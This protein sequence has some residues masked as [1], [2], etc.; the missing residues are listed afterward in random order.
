MNNKEEEE[1][2]TIIIDEQTTDKMDKNCVVK[3]K[4]IMLTQSHKQ[5]KAKSNNNNWIKQLKIGDKIDAKDSNKYDESI[6]INGD[7][8]SEHGVYTN[9]RA[10]AINELS[11]KYKLKGESINHVLYDNTSNT[12]LYYI[13]YI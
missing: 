10:S 9:N 3:G 7:R 4:F 11:V 12:F 8:L 13:K 2:Q 5:I 1:D 6:N